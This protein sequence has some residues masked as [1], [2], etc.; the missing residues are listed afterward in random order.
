MVSAQT[1]TAETMKK[2]ASRLRTRMETSGARSEQVQKERESRSEGATRGGGE[3]SLVPVPPRQ[4]FQREQ[5]QAACH[6]RGEQQDEQGFARL[7]QRL[8]APEQEGIERG[9]HAQPEAERPE[10]QRQE[11][12]KQ[13]A[14]STVHD[15]RPVGRVIAGAKI[16]SHMNTAYMA[17]KPHSASARPMTAMVISGPLPRQS[18]VSASTLRSPIGACT[19]IAATNTK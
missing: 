9:F 5:A 10:M 12:R 15:E 3:P 19:A 1:R 7:D 11:Q 6:V 8:L 16:G 17:R 14:R 18:K 4:E 13:H 2:H